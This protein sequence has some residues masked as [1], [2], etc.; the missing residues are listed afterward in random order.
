MV[1]LSFSSQTRR[2]KTS[3]K[4]RCKCSKLHFHGCACQTLPQCA[5]VLRGLTR[6]TE[7]CNLP[8]CQPHLPLK[9]LA[10]S[11]ISIKQVVVVSLPL[12]ETMKCSM[13]IDI[14]SFVHLNHENKNRGGADLLQVGCSA[15]FL[16]KF[17]VS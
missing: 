6:E 15:V 3:T 10:Q 14:Y 4:R 8:L 5:V 17:L 7:N 13:V 16:Q 1:I 11:T 2:N 12:F 9:T